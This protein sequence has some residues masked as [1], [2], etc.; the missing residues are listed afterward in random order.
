MRPKHIRLLALGV[1]LTCAPAMRA[2]NF[3][4]DIREMSR[5]VAG[6]DRFGLAIEVAVADSTGKVLLRRRV[7][8]TRIGQRM[9]QRVDSMELLVTPGGT[10]M[11]DHVR[12][13]IAL[14]V[15]DSSTRAP[16]LPAVPA[17]LDSAV[18]RL[19]S[20]RL[21]AQTDS[22]REYR[23]HRRE[24]DASGRPV[25]ADLVMDTRTHL[26]RVVRYQYADAG[27]LT[28]PRGA[29]VTATYSWNRSPDADALR[30]ERYVTLGTRGRDASPAPAFASYRL[31]PRDQ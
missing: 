3:A 27:E 4:D 31:M 29:T 15:A 16:T 11:V 30:I 6:L 22:T 19:D 21:M 23:L 5:V 14:Q 10:V 13:R 1:A 9:L 25:R 17:Q 7:E 2:Q 26:P 12:R 8:S 18:A 24:E 20:V 28:G